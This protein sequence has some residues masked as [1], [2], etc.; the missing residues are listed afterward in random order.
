[1]EYQAVTRHSSPIKDAYFELH[2]LAFPDRPTVASLPVSA[3]LAAAAQEIKHRL[4]LIS[5]VLRR[6]EAAGWAVEL[7]GDQVVASVP[8]AAAEGWAFL[9]RQGVSDVLLPLLEKGSDLPTAAAAEA[10]PTPA[11]GALAPD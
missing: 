9:V 5:E 10:T 1:M 6:L 8:V 4:N 11:V 2:S 3:R 7:V